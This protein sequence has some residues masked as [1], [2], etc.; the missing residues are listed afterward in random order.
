MK[1]KHTVFGVIL[2]SLML[3]PTGEAQ[4]QNSVYKYH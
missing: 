3:L 2:S 4:A 1:L